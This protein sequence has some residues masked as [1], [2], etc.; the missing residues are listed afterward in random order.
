MHRSNLLISLAETPALLPRLL[1][2]LSD[3]DY[4]QP[5]AEGTWSIGVVLVHMRDVERI[6]HERIGRMLAEDNPY[7]LDFDS[8]DLAEERGYQPGDGPRMIEEFARLRAHTIEM[9]ESTEQDR[10][11]VH[12]RVGP[13]SVFYSGRH[14]VSHDLQHIAQIVANPAW[15]RCP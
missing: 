3:A 4:E 8:D 14:L 15:A 12:S 9:I 13:V 2:G 6:Y 5:G 10:T 1:H 7:L 11:G